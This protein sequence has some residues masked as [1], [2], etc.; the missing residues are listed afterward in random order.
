MD[1]FTPK[2]IFIIV[3]TELSYLVKKTFN[4]LLVLRFAKAWGQQYGDLVHPGTKR[5]YTAGHRPAVLLHLCVPKQPES[6]ASTSATPAQTR[7][8]PERGDVHAHGLQT[9]GEML[10]LTDQN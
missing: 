6:L 4:V 9:K 2:H 1:D 8:W 10:L 5:G 3:K 7:P